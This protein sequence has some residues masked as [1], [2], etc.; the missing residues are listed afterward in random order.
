MKTAIEALDEVRDKI[1]ATSAFGGGFASGLDHAL[2]IVSWVKSD[3]QAAQK[4]VAPKKGTKSPSHRKCIKCR[5]VKKVSWQ[6][7][8][9]A[10]EIDGEEIE[11]GWWCE[12]CYE[13]RADDI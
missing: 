13:D 6:C 5:N 2:K 1:L 10:A 11:W 7:N 9:Y 3:I 12:D 8:P 4:T